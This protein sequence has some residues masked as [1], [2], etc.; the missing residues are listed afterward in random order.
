MAK[1]SAG[2]PRI[3]SQVS[4]VSWKVGIV[5]RNL[6]PWAEVSPRKVLARA[7]RRRAQRFTFQRLFGGGGFFAGFL[8]GLLGLK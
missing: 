5:A 3:L 4:R 6:Q 1:R 7:V 8:K 2:L